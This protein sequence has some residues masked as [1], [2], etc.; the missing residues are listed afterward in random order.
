MGFREWLHGRTAAKTVDNRANFGQRA[1]EAIAKHA[2]GEMSLEAAVYHMTGKRAYYISV[3][4]ADGFMPLSGFGS[5][6]LDDAIS[7]STWFY[8]CVVANARAASDLPAIVQTK[9]SAGEWQRDRNHP[10]NNLLAVPFGGA[11]GWPRWSWKQLIQTAFMQLPGCGN[12]YL[13]PA[14]VRD[15]A[16]RQRVSALFPL[17]APGSVRAIENTAR[18]GRGPLLGWSLG[19]GS[20]DLPLDALVNVMSP[21]AGSLWDGIAPME[22]AAKAI[23][24]DAI[25]ASRARYNMENRVSPGLV[26]QIQDAWGYGATDTQEQ[27]ILAKLAADYTEAA[28]TGKPLVIGGGTAISTAPSPQE[29]QVIDTRKFSR[30]EIMAVCGT[31]PPMIGDYESATLQNF[32]QAFLAWWDGHLFPMSHDFYGALNSQAIWPIYG[33]G[34]RLW[35]DVSRTNIGVRLMDARADVAQKLKD[36][37]YT[38][39]TASAE[40]GLDLAFVEELEVYNT[41]L[42]RAGRDVPITDDS[43]V[44]PDDNGGE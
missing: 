27:A 3:P 43:D 1:A 42:A 22:V 15:T 5:T 18:D 32:G 34:T 14:L 25:S 38:A 20:P 29:L 26:I 21:T 6:Q 16:T 12:A 28:D 2:A 33:T 40:T 9:D 24:T 13:K 23:E 44:T 17:T 7:A 35:Y 10:L 11:I 41:D 39:N 19:D 4:D 30:D 31:P 36:L 37:G 8:A